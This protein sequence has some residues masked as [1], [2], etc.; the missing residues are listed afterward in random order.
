MDE[1]LYRILYPYLTDKK[2]QQMKQYMQHGSVSTYEHCVQVAVLCFLCNRMW[3]LGADVETLVIAALLHDL[4][5]YDWHD[6]DGGLHRLHGYRHPKRAA[7]NAARYLGVNVEVQDIIRTHMWPLTIT[8]IP[9]SR[10]AWLVC[11]VD[12]YVSLL[13]SIRRRK[14]KG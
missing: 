2:V 4:Y 9:R 5:L 7:R 12:K 10:E 14:Q 6:R 8:Q 11:M 13:E 1:E 3:K